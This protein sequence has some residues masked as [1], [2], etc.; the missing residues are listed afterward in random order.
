MKNCDK[1]RCTGRVKQVKEEDGKQVAV[2]ICPN[3]RCRNYREEFAEEVLDAPA[4][5]GEDK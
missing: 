5:A 3:P 4:G 2:Y 1:C